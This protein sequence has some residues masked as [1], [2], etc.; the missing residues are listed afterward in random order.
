[1]SIEKFYEHHFVIFGWFLVQNLLLLLVLLVAV[2][3]QGTPG[4]NSSTRLMDTRDKKTLQCYWKET[5]GNSIGV[6]V[7]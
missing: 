4:T 6:P 7:L 2:L 3:S 5:P 1:M